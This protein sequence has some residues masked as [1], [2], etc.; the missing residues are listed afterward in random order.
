[1]DGF[2]FC[3]DVLKDVCL[4]QKITCWCFVLGYNDT[5]YYTIQRIFNGWWYGGY[6]VQFCARSTATGTPMVGT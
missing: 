6:K 5:E 1:M 4:F 2:A 3:S